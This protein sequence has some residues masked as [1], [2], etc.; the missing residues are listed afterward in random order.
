MLKTWGLIP[1][2]ASCDFDQSDE[3]EFMFEVENSPIFVL[4]EKEEVKIVA[5]ASLSF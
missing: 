1:V 2:T 3:E 5:T 4:F